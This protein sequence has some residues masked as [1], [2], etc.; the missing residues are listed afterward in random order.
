MPDYTMLYES[1]RTGTNLLL[2]LTQLLKTIA[3]SKWF[4]ASLVAIIAYRRSYYEAIFAVILALIIGVISEADV[5]LVVALSLLGLFLRIGTTH[6]REIVQ[7]R[8]G[9]V[10]WYAVAEILRG[11]RK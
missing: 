1:I 2:S 3:L 6:E 5:P 7:P 8:F 10:N 9:R 4:W 11:R